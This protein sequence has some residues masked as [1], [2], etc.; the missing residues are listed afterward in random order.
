MPWRVEGTAEE[1]VAHP[2][3]VLYPRGCG[4]CTRRNAPSSRGRRQGAGGEGWESHCAGLLRE[5]FHVRAAG[6]NAEPRTRQRIMASHHCV[7]QRAT[8][9]GVGPPPA[10]DLPQTHAST[11]SWP[12]KRSSPRRALMQTSTAMS[13][14]GKGCAVSHADDSDPAQLHQRARSARAAHRTREETPF[15]SA[16]SVSKRAAAWAS[17]SAWEIT[18]FKAAI[19]RALPSGLRPPH[20]AA[21]SGLPARTL[22]VGHA[23]SHE[24][25]PETN[26]PRAPLRLHTASDA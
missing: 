20:F 1:E 6:G 11:P 23:S 22:V 15:A 14:A 16:S 8:D 12:V 26:A 9:E 18:R 3:G 17:A 7:P 24:A 19:R 10:M 5:L 2:P 25:E 4:A 13:S 21:S